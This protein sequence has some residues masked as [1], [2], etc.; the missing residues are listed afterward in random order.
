M[1]REKFDLKA[2]PFVIRPLSDSD[3]GGY[4]IEYPGHSRVH[5]GWRNAGRSDRQRNGRSQ[6]VPTNNEGIRRFHPPAS[7]LFGVQRTMAAARPQKPSRPACGPSWDGRC[8]P[9]YPR[10]IASGRGPGGKAAPALI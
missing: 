7:G 8:K 2:Y 5:V 10:H 3:G 6:F 4:L 1:S 9:E